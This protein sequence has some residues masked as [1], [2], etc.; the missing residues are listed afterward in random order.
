MDFGTG[1]FELI[2]KGGFFVY[3]IILCSI[4]GLAIFL[5][6]MWVLQSKNIIPE[7]FLEQLYRFLS[8][9]KLGEAEVYAR[10]NSSSISRVALAALENSY[11]PKEELREEIEE[12]GRKETLELMRYAEGLGTISNVSTLLGLLGTISGMIKIFRVIADKP[13]VNPPEL[14]GGIS[15]ALYTTAFGLLV[16]IPAFIAYKYVVGRADELISLMEE[17]GRKI[18]EYVIVARESENTTPT[19]PRDISG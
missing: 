3:P 2:Q 4:V 16:A 9:G 11:K 6:K 12:A 5:Q 1:V 15:E 18:M 8:Q 13:I 10:A 17:E 14:A 7:V 19:D